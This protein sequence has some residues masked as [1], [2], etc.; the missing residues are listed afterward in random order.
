M[1]LPLEDAIWVYSISVNISIPILPLEYYNFANI[2]NEKK[3]A[4]PLVLSEGEY[5]I[6]IIGDPPFGLL[7]SLLEA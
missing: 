3:V 6:E 7:Y 4:K 2:F 1:V 5:A